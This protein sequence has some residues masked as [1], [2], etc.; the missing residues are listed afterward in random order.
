MNPLSHF[1][2]SILAVA[3]VVFSAQA[4]VKMPSIFSSHMVL[5]RDEACPV[6][7]WAEAGEEVTVTIGAQKHTAKTGDNGKWSVKLTAM[8]ASS[9]PQVL[10]V[11]GKNSIKFEDVLVGEVWLCGGQSNM[12][13][14]VSQSSNA[15]K[16]IAAANH[17]RIRHIKVP[18]VT[19]DK[20]QDDVKTSGWL[21][22][23]PQTVPGF[24]AVGYFFALAIQKD[25]DV[26]VGLI[27]SNW[28]GTRIEPWTP[29][30]GFQSV[31]ALKEN[32]AD[33]LSTFPSK[34]A[35]GVANSGSPLAM[36][37]AMIHP[38][39]P[40]GL[41]G[42][43]WYQ[44]ESNNGEGMLYTEKMRALISGWRSVWHKPD[45]PFLFVQLAPYRYG[46][47]PENLAGIWEAQTA[48]LKIPN[49]GMCVITDI[50]TVND[51]HPPNKQ[52]VGRRLALWALANTY[53]KDVKVYSGPLF[54]S[55]K[56]DGAAIRVSFD[57]VGGGLISRDGKALS[58]FQ[59]AGADG[60]FAEAEAKID[61][62]TLVV[63]AASVEEPKF[64]RF[65]W[66]QLAEPNLSNKEG[67]PA[68]PF[69]TDKLLPAAPP[70]PPTKAAPKK[71]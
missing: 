17:K 69:R 6:W 60:K 56:A 34:N 44:G 58:H 24:T 48:T 19:S 22:T 45:M 36:Y 52:E 10:T 46:G 21:V 28:G 57:H 47:S 25:L 9:E 35:Q 13:W 1:R 61:G 23:T 66:H 65:G 26:P 62:E 39:V 51:I 41:R 63:R 15:Q 5:Q 4:D 43:L 7:G 64:V 49:T 37:N 50:S 11:A 38:L 20:P 2:L 54:K 68:S 55:A 31:P 42:A 30:I 29:P 33:K 18:H 12:E 16:E 67:L 40:Y 32:F 59:V 3:F 53:G 27:G 71:K 8:K 14:A 70:Q